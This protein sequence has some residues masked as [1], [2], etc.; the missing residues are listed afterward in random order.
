MSWYTTEGTDSLHV[1]RSETKYIRNL[2]SL[3]FSPKI[4][5]KQLSDL[6]EKA[7]KILNANGFK[8]E[9]INQSPTSIMSYAEKGFLDVDLCNGARESASFSLYFNEPCSLAVTV[10]GKDHFT[11]RS[12]LS[13]RAVS[14]TRSIA[15]EAEELFDRQFE[16]AYS[17]HFGYL[18]PSLMRCGSGEFFSALLFL[19]AAA[20]LGEIDKLSLICMRFGASLTPAFNHPGNSGDM[21]FL[22]FS[23]HFLSDG[24]SCARG[25]DA[26]ITSIIE[27][28]KLYEGIIFEEK[29]KIIIDG[30]HRAMG[31]LLFAKRIGEDEMLSHLS[32][33]RLCVADPTDKND[34]PQISLS[35]LNLLLAEGLNS[36]V[37]S[38]FPTILNCEELEERRAELIKGLISGKKC[39]QSSTASAK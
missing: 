28:E 4:D 17:P 12:L 27:K 19:P 16:F 9:R 22:S 7:E 15:I 5:A 20:R 29:R 37:S 26:L 33:I 35:T 39:E 3:P 36:S 1:I 34:A 38:S 6:S 18:S 2:T 31:A 23:P 11:V 10:G 21:Y 14:E 8:K 32:S 24:A 13:G 30:A 25:F